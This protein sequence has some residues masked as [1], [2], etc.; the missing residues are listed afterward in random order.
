MTA[1][2][3]VL[4]IVGLAYLTYFTGNNHLKMLASTCQG[5]RGNLVVIPLLVS[6]FLYF[7]F[8]IAAMLILNGPKDMRWVH[9]SFAFLLVL[10][11]INVND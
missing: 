6:Y 8:A 1:F 10:K 3:S 4:G 2:V 5:G 7:G 11:V 9:I